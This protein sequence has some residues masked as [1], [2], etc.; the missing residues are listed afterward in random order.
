MI[1]TDTHAETRSDRK[2]RTILDAATTLF[3]SQGYDGTSMDDVASLAGVSKPTVYKH[4][5]DK[6]QLFAAIVLATTD[7]AVGLV[8][9]VTETFANSRDV[10]R[11]LQTLARAFIARL[12]EPDV[13]RLRRLV[14]ATA[15]RFPQVGRTWYDQGFERALD[16]LAGAFEVLTAQGFL[17]VDEPLVAANHYV[18]LLLWI[19][20]NRAMFSGG[21]PYTPPQ[22]DACADAAVDAF[23]RAYGRSTPPPRARAS[24]ARRHAPPD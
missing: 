14:I 7:Q 12:M 2:R 18:G 8:Q 4:F 23:L 19:P 11:S 21:S 3:L 1:D 16:A 13:L 20:V 15:D 9:L 17:N 6:E 10:Q 24:A 22:L 5:F